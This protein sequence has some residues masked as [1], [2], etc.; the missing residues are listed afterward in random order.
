MKININKKPAAPVRELQQG[1]AFLF[2]G[3]FRFITYN[4]IGGV[5]YHYF[6]VDSQGSVCGE[7][8]DIH[9]LRANYDKSLV[10]FIKE[11]NLE[12]D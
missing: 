12:V 2:D 11:V 3:D 8:V 9:K 5:K 6:V 4:N 7:F 1:D 10:K